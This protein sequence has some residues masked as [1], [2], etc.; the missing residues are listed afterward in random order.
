MSNLAKN[1]M[2]SIQPRAGNKS[3]KKLGTICVGP[4]VGHRQEARDSVADFEVLIG[5]GT[6]VN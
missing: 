1:G 3:Y 4:S 6:A 5:K 2:F